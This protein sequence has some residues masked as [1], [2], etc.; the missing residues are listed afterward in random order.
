MNSKQLL[1]D[2]AGI[3]ASIGNDAASDA[4]VLLGHCLGLTHA[5]L[6]KNQNDS[7]SDSHIEL[8]YQYLMRR[9]SGEPRAYILGFE[10]FYGEQFEVNSSVLIPRPETEMIIELSAK[11]RSHLDTILDIGTGSG[12]IA[13][14]LAKIFPNARVVAVD[15]S[16]D[17]LNVARRNATRIL[18]PE[19]R[20]EWVCAD[21]CDWQIP[22]PFDLVASNPPYLAEHEVKPNHY[23]PRSAFYAG[24]EGV[25]FYRAI[26]QRKTELLKDH[27][28]ML[29]EIGY[30]QAG[31][32]Q[33]LF[34]SSVLHFDLAKH[35]R[36]I[37][38]HE[39]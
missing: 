26:A 31:Q 6:I 33:Q 3:L 19:N 28:L 14:A 1:R 15:I 34:P 5:D 22:Y 12:C 10:N 24:E 2:G 32:V 25:D 16:P 29:M 7:V 37:E 30:Q 4:R 17:A 21:F 20:I 35:P 13:I 8:Y 36:V 23:E 39:M 27:G 38:Y 11:R 9:R 18:G